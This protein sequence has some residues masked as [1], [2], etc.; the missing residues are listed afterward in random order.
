MKWLVALLPA[1][2]PVSGVDVLDKRFTCGAHGIEDQKIAV[3]EIGKNVGDE[4][5]PGRIKERAKLSPRLAGG[6][7]KRLEGHANVGVGELSGQRGDLPIQAIRG[8]F[9]GDDF[10]C[11]I[12]L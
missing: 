2:S 3:V 12:A 10:P 9:P 7:V 6:V 4:V 1:Q 11:S 8:S 5:V